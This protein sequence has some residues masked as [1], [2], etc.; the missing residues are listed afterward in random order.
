[1][2]KDD[3][4]K[5]IADEYLNAVQND[6]WNG[7]RSNLYPSTLTVEQMRKIAAEQP[8]GVRTKVVLFK[9]L[10]FFRAH[11]LCPV[12]STELCYT[13]CYR[14]LPHFPSPTT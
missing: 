7:F 9:V 4:G 10:L 8:P 11:H 13:S 14:T 6:N 5:Y 2:V 1:M 3:E 12:R